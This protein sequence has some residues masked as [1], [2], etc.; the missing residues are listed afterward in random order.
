MNCICGHPEKDHVQG[1]RCRVPDCPCE[2]FRPG[3]TLRETVT[4]ET[5]GFP[6]VPVRRRPSWGD[7]SSPRR[8]TAPLGS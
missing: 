5:A 6:E 1:G 7:T 8:A 2:L 3:D 4:P